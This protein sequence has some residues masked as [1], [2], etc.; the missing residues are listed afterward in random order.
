MV[1]GLRAGYKLNAS[2]FESQGTTLARSEFMGLGV[3]AILL[4]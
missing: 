2:E 3:G 4:H 1:K